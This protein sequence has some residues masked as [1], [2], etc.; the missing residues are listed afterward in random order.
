MTVPSPDAA[1]HPALLTHYHIVQR[2][3]LIYCL[4]IV[5]GIIK[6]ENKIFL[7]DERGPYINV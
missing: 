4:N 1:A 5:R 7:T 6:L 2:T 3:L